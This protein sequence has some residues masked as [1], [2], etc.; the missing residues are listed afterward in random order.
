[1]SCSETSR[2]EMSSN[3][4]VPASTTDT[5]DAA[6]VDQGLPIQNVCELCERIFATGPSRRG[7]LVH[8]LDGRTPINF[9]AAA[10]GGCHQVKNLQR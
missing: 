8:R 3:A 1:M 5:G 9:Q 10:S 7:N 6:D 4:V 2:F